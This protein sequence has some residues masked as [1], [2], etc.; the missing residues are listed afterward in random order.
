M[1]IAF[2]SMAVVL[3]FRRRVRRNSQGVTCTLSNA[4]IVVN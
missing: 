4:K 3:D 1:I 2:V